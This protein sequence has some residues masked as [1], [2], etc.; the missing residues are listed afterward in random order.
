MVATERILLS[1]RQQIAEKGIL[2]LRV[3]DVAEGAY[4]SVTQIYRYFGDRNGLLARVLGDMYEEFLET[5]LQSI[6]ERLDSLDSVTIDDIVDVLPSPTDE[7]VVIH[8]GVRLQ[9]LATAV[10]NNALRERLS[11]I[12]RRHLVRWNE[13]IDNVSARMTNDESMDSRV[14]TI[15]IAMQ[16]AYY[17]YL[18]GDD[19]FTEE[20]YRQ[21]LKDKL[22]C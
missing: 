2:G 17:R 12:A 13:C 8:S 14:F 15:M 20:E 5:S 11:Q 6:V 7:C 9:I 21:F 18:L 19:G 16:M 22:R 10:T 3:A 1:A 4:S